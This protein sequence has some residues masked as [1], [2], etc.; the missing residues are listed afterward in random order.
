M[1]PGKLL[2]ILLVEDSE[3][4]AALLRE[5]IRLSNVDDLRLDY[6]HSLQEAID[7]FRSNH[8]DAML[9]DLTLPDSSGLETIRRVRQA[10]TDMPI[11]VLTGVDDENTGVEAVRLGAQDYLVKGRVDGRL[12]ARAI[13][14]AI[15]RKRMEAE[16]RKARDEL[17]IRVE[18]RT[19]TI[20]QQAMFLE[21]YFRHSLTPMVFLDRSFNFIR[22]NQAYARADQKRVE[23]FAG[24][25]HFEFYPHAENQAIFENVVRTK[26]PFVASA[27]PFTYPDHPEWGITYWDWTL[28]PILDSKGEVELLIFSLEDVTEHKRADI[29]TDFTNTLLE[30]FAQKTSRK[31]YLDSVVKAVH[32][33]SGCECVGIRLTDSDG[34]VPF[35]SCVGYSDEFLALENELCLKKDSC[36]CIRAIS[37]TPESQDWPLT[38][39]RGSFSSNNSIDFVK[40]LPGRA[41]KRY[42]GTCMRFGFAS[43]AVIPIRYRDEILGAIHLADKKENK[44]P[45]ETVE[46]LENIAMLIGE[47]VHRFDIETELR[48]S[49]ERYRQLVELSPDGIGVERDDRIAFINTAGAKLLGYKRPEELIGR[50]VLDFVHPD[51]RKRAHLLL[52]YQRRKGKELPMREE[53]FIRANG[54]TL[55]VEVAATLLIYQNR[56]SMQIVFR[57]ITERKLAQERILADQKQLRQ[58]T[59]ELVLAEERERHD[60][61]TAMHDSIGPILAFTKRELGA[62][63]KKTPSDIADSLE[64]IGANIS[65]VVTQTRTLT[66]DLSPPTL[67]TLGF[68]TAVEE[69]TERF[70]KEHNLR[71]SF[72]KSDEPKPLTDHV[73]VLLYRS[74]RE[75]LINI[76]KHAKAGSVKVDISRVNNEIQVTVKDDGKG[77]DVSA[78]NR[79]ETR[80]KGLGLFSIRER[81]MHIGGRFEIKSKRGKGT[82]ATLTAPLELD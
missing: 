42:R 43:L 34:F 55:D 79:R 38:T 61:A 13:R 32:D 46:F 49:E 21:A 76:A 54:T 70:C 2:K 41:K 23:D 25:N 67:Y 68:E 73:K 5:N 14:Y 7:H 75:L 3:S 80:P 59:A 60:I 63:R 40:N 30:L 33:W 72:N 44:M 36:I 29:R 12:I 8:I 39:P 10:G 9:L 22:V 19:R 82:S 37:Q 65:E 31:E 53:K 18:E 74:I 28:V 45:A 56:P 81:L 11:V 58:L 27:K 50:P 51:Y 62:L 57:D 71:Y 1:T 17:E 35:K 16:L 77:L 6:A 24:H 47:A 78:L 66:F 64:N 15:E 52:E 69:L 20:R 26:T 4:D 48:E